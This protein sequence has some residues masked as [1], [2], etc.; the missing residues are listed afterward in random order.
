MVKPRVSWAVVDDDGSVWQF[1]SSEHNRNMRAAR[2]TDDCLG[3]SGESYEILTSVV[4][5]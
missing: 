5:P 4:A 2:L 3:Y 1:Y